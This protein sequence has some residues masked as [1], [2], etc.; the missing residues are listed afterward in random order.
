MQNNS[1]W[2][3]PRYDGAP[4]AFRTYRQ[5][6]KGYKATVVLFGQ[7]N[8]HEAVLKRFFTIF[9]GKTGI[10]QP[11]PGKD[12]ASEEERGEVTVFATWCEEHA[13]KIEADHLAAWVA[14][15]KAEADYQGAAFKKPDGTS[16]PDLW[17]FFLDWAAA[18]YDIA[19][20][21]AKEAMVSFKQRTNEAPHTASERY[22][23]L[24]ARLQEGTV[25]QHDLARWFWHG[26]H[27][28]RMKNY[29]S[30]E[31]VRSGGGNSR[32]KGWTLDFVVASANQYYANSMLSFTAAEEQASRRKSE[33]VLSTTEQAGSDGLAKQMRDMQAQLNQLTTTMTALAQRASSGAGASSSRPPQQSQRQADSRT[34]QRGKATGNGGNGGSGNSSSSGGASRGD[35]HKLS[36]P[37]PITG[38]MP[39]CDY[40]G[41]EGN[42][43]THSRDFCFAA[44]R[45]GERTA[46]KRPPPPPRRRQ[47]TTLA[48]RGVEDVEAADYATTMVSRPVG[49]QRGRIT[50]VV[51]RPQPRG[52]APSSGPAL[53]G[54]GLGSASWGGN[55]AVGAAFGDSAPS[56]PAVATSLVITAAEQ[57]RQQQAAA[58][59]AGDCAAPA[60]ARAAPPGLTDVG[61][62]STSLAGREAFPQ[63]FAQ[64]QPALLPTQAMTES[65]GQGHLQSYCRL[66][67]VTR[68]CWAGLTGPFYHSRA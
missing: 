44:Q 50:V 7:L 14:A 47:S 51:R 61:W 53:N 56:A 66:V 67:K 39:P 55:S 11:K 22:K 31:F 24:A 49:L 52:D 13:E 60:A 40:P 58:D 2:D 6:V 1:A 35:R 10:M 15:G 21:K 25:S 9:T 63:G 30:E 36:E 19:D 3:P 42:R 4:G 62:P 59:Q 27:D 29:I 45:A 12:G 26:L 5:R 54:T 43:A 16:V 68:A 17:D 28:E 34:D 41:C 64:L 46:N 20:P 38:S 65:S 57:R 18:Q 48:T 37:G 33:R 8:K 23:A 32:S